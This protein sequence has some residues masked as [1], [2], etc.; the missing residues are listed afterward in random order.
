MGSISP[1]K[2]PSGGGVATLGTAKASNSPR[3]TCNVQA[4]AAFRGRKVCNNKGPPKAA[5]VHH[6]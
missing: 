2:I 1:G 6:S 5:L 3:H 4:C